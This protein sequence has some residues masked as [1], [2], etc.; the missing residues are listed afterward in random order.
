MPPTVA[1]ALG[2]QSPMVGDGSPTEAIAFAGRRA[3]R[4]RSRWCP[5]QQRRPPQSLQPRCERPLLA[6]T[7]RSLH[8][9]DS[10]RLQ[11]YFQRPDEPVGTPAR[12]PGLYGAFFVKPLRRGSSFFLRQFLCPIWSPFL[13]PDPH[14]PDA[15][16]RRGCQGWA[17]RLRCH[18]LPS[19]PGHTLTAP[20]TTAHSVWSG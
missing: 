6:L 19:S 3:P 9:R 14:I 12:D 1:T 13:R 18:A 11:S 16:A 8:C 7:A 20:S 5:A 2:W 15:V 17:S 10:V 4:C